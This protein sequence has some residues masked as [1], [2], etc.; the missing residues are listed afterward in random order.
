MKNINEKVITTPFIGM[1]SECPWLEMVV[2]PFL[3]K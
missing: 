2:I 3:W 1:I